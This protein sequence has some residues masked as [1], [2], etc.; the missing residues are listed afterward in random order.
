MRKF[1]LYVGLVLFP[2]L[3]WAQVTTSNVE[4][5][6]TDDAGTAIEMVNVVLKHEPTGTVYVT[7]T[8]SDG[9]YNFDNVRVG[10]PYVLTATL[11]GYKEQKVVNIF[12]EIGNRAS[13]N[14]KMYADRIELQEAVVTYNAAINTN[15]QGTETS[16]SEVQINQMPTVNREIADFARITPQAS[17]QNVGGQTAINVAGMNNRYNSI[18]I[19]GAVNNDVFGLA[20][21]GTNGGQTGGSPISLDAIEQIQVVVAPYDVKLSGFAGGGINAVTRSGSNTVEGSLYYITRNQALAGKT[22]TDVEGAERNPLPDFSSQIMGF[23]VGAPIVKDKLFI[24][25]NGEFQNDNTPAPVQVNKDDLPGNLTLADIQAFEA[26]LKGFGYDPGTW[27]QDVANKLQSQ[28][29]LIKLDWNLNEKNTLSLRHS[30]T[31]NISESPGRSTLQRINFS[32]SG[33]YFPST[34]NSTALEL[35]TR[36]ASNKSN[37]LIIGYT[38]VNDDRGPL[39]DAFPYISIGGNL[40]AGSEQFSTGNVLTQNILTITDNFDLYKGKHH[41]TFGTHNEYYDINNVFIRQAFGSYNYDS[42][43]Q[44]TTGAGIPTQYDISYSLNAAD[45]GVAPD[46]SSAAAAFKVLQLGFYAQDE[47]RVSDK[48]KV[49]GGLRIDIPMFLNDPADDGYFND[50]T[51]A[52]IEAAGYDLKGAKAGQAP[53]PQLLFSPRIGF[54]YDI[55]GDQS[56]IL[57][58]GVGIFTSRIPYVWPGGMFNNNGASVGGLRTFTADFTNSGLGF[59]DN[60]FNQYRA[61]SFG[62]SDAIPQGQMDLFSEDFKYP[63]VLRSNIAVDKKIF[64]GMVATADVLF[65]KTL[66]NI[67]YENVNIKPSTENLTGSSDDRPYY[68]RRDPI[69]SK[70]TGIYLASNTNE[71][72]TVNFTFQL[73]K[74]V[75]EGLSFMGAY[76]YG[77][78][79][80]VYDG[81]SSQNSSQWRGINSVAGRNVVG[82][83]ISDFDMGHRVVLSGAYRITY[84]NRFATTFSLFFNGQSGQRFSYIYDDNGNLNNEDSRE[85]NLI[86]VPKD[87]NDI[88]L[89]DIAGGATAAEQWEALNAFIESDDYLSSRRGQYAE[90]NGARTPFETV[91]DLRIAQDIAIFKTNAGRENKIQITFDVFNLTNLINKNWGRRYFVSEGQ[92]QVIRFE[93]FEDGTRTPTFTFRERD[94]KFDILDQGVYSSRWQ[95]QIGFRYLF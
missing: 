11:M 16:I 15:K 75:T 37:N 13:Y 51:A 6:V 8:R 41:F 40:N 79:K 1:L 55:N 90:R 89:V 63:Q 49:T 18:F 93:K 46:A 74:Q 17:V 91:L 28:K 88:N 77:M 47:Y 85:R 70:Y 52:A 29:L 65:T 26:K 60:P 71:G 21:T 58:G 32:N 24:F 45:D 87:Q 34:T 78:A 7:T 92:Y 10:G 61:S 25:V 30:Y 82:L 69:D 56:F 38:S 83:G 3:S 42:V 36:I 64:W 14:I 35:N 57:R 12:L 33:V 22:P 48:F 95:A 80:S 5:R 27:D 73:T 81:T 50:N 67:Y 72:Y 31:K 62:R 66:N 4:G 54:N 86:Y 19:D 68:D 76:N 94:Q 23:R 53:K 84:A 9:R 20:A 2:A 43:S 39:G 44:F 59:N